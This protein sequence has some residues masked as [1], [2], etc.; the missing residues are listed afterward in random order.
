M[1]YLDNAATTKPNISALENAQ[2]YLTEEFFNPSAKYRGGIDASL[3]IKQAK[4]TFSKIFGA[5]MAQE[6]VYTPFR[7]VPGVTPNA[8]EKHRIK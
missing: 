5:C 1:I 8:S 7:K 3:V 2:K 6:T 4:Q